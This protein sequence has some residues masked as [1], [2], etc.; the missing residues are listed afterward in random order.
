MHEDHAYKFSLSCYIT[1]HFKEDK[2][3]FLLE[4]FPADKPDFYPNN[5]VAVRFFKKPYFNIGKYFNSDYS[6][7]YLSVFDKIASENGL[8][9]TTNYIRNN[10]LFGFI[11]K[12][13]LASLK[14]NLS[15]DVKG[16]EK[17]CHKY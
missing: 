11:D 15:S 14:S 8:V 16:V 12:Y 7:N 2:Y 9:R 17:E 6:S 5:I 3:S 4:T 13:C 10:S 1:L